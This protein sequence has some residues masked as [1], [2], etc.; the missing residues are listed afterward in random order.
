MNVVG[1]W[2]TGLMS[3]FV[4]LTPASPSWD[5]GPADIRGGCGDGTVPTWTTLQHDN[6]SCDKH[7]QILLFYI[8]ASTAAFVDLLII[9]HF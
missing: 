7:L 3:H 4:C 6:L 1:Q 2:L 8:L 5:C 9:S